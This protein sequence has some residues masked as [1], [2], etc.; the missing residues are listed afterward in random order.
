MSS[1]DTNRAQ[2]KG[3]PANPRVIK[4]GKFKK[5]K[6]SIAEH[7]EFLRYRELLVYPHKG[8]Y[9][10]IGG[11]MR[12]RALKELGYTEAPCKVIDA[13]ATVEQLKA[14]CLID[15][16]GYG[17]WDWDALL[18]DWDASLLDACAI[19]IPQDELPDAEDTLGAV[20]EDDAPCDPPKSPVTKEGDL[21]ALGEHRLLCGSCTEGV[22]WDALIGGGTADCIITDPPYG[23]D[24]RGAA[25]DRKI[26]N[27]NLSGDEF[28]EFLAG[29]FSHA[30][31]HLKQ[32]GA[33]YVWHGDA[34]RM[35]F[36]EAMQRVGWSVRQVLVWVKNAFVLGRQDYQWQHESCLYGW[37]DGAPHWFVGLRSLSSVIEQPA[38]DLDKATKDQ[39]LSLLKE[40]T[41]L[42]QTVIRENKPLRSEAHPTMKPIKLIA[43]LVH[44]STLPGQ[45]VVD[46]F[47][48]SGTTLLACEQ[49]RRRC[50]A[51][52]LDPGFCDVIIQRWQDLVGQ[53][54]VLLARK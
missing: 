44:N 37:K 43:R 5:L 36:L 28:V 20:K 6:Q 3:L 11:N 26:A 47:C 29:V 33:F 50:L 21:Y 51:M 41:A 49:L 30:D 23:V 39:L 19:D 14:Y 54:A 1:L 7:P 42:P 38:L 32:G 52:E 10:I 35:P 48:G 15:N 25:C 13:S 46:P 40:I 4:D 18:R 2:I 22:S 53:K 9:V 16:S 34:K 12:Y 27:D 8:H 24:Y 45:T 17:E 31:A